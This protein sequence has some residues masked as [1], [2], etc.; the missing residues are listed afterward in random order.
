MC[1]E[2]AK[3][4]YEESICCGDFTLETVLFETAIRQA[5]EHAGESTGI[6]G[7]EATKEKENHE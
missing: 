3:R 7:V 2:K 1:V 5:K 6:V 4:E